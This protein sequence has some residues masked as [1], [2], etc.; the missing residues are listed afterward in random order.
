MQ[1]ICIYKNIARVFSFSRKVSKCKS[2]KLIYDCVIYSMYK[3]TTYAIPECSIHAY[4]VYIYVYIHTYIIEGKLTEIY[5]TV[6]VIF[7][8]E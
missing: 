1:Q 6:N 5:H 7:F 2:L 3:Y 4:C 8:R